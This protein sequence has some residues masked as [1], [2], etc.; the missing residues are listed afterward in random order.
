MPEIPEAVVAEATDHKT[1]E[2]RPVAPETVSVIGIADTSKLPSGTVAVTPD[3][4]QPNMIINVVSPMVALAVRFGYDWCMAF[5]GI[6]GA[7]GLGGDKLIHHTDLVS[8]LTTAAIVATCVAGLGLVKNFATV[9][10]GLEKKFPL[11]SG[12]V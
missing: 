1:T 4:H 7:G 11:A 10:S 5:G 6:T 2:S 8:L 9:F 12:S 3:P